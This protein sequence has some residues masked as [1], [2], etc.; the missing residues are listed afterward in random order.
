MVMKKAAIAVFCIGI[1][2]IAAAF[3]VTLVVENNETLLELKEWFDVEI[4]PKDMD[5]L[6]YTVEMFGVELDTTTQFGIDMYIL[7]PELYKWGT[8]MAILGLLG[9]VILHFQKK[10][11]V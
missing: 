11:A 1:L 4:T 5:S 10:R 2:V 7:T 6:M 9:T 3:A 8:I